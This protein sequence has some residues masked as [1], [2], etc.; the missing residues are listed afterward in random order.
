MQEHDRQFS[1]RVAAQLPGW[2][3]FISG[4]MLIGATVLLPVKRNLDRM[5]W[6]RDLMRTQARGLGDQETSY[7]QFH[8]AIKSDDPILLQ[9]LAYYQ[10][11]LK[12]AGTEPLLSPTSSTDGSASS[13][14]SGQWQEMP[15]IEALLHQP[16]PGEGADRRPPQPPDT[17]L[18]R[19]TRGRKRLML[20]G[21][22]LAFV[23]VGMLLPIGDNRGKAKKKSRKPNR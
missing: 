3:F 13:T 9:R 6:R 10:L 17:R 19:L 4:L 23:Y 5:Q 14:R 1:Q 20:L 8:E 7:R 16:L 21:I 12:P 18:S 2:V 11:H 22:G 15:T